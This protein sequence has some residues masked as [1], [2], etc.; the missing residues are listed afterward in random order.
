ML[1]DAGIGL[2]SFL[3]NFFM[4]GLFGWLGERLTRRLRV[5]TLRAV[6]RQPVAWFDTPDNSVGRLTA[7][8]AEDASLVKATTGGSLAQGVSALCSLL[9]G[10]IIAFISSWQLALLVGHIRLICRLCAF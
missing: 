6:L 2:A 5:A 1:N 10:I 4:W 9:T 7:R 3:G 8:L